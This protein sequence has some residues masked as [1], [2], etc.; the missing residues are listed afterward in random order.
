MASYIPY[1]IA[2]L[3]VN[4]LI[5]L[6]LYL[7]TV[8]PMRT[9]ANGMDLLR[10]QDFSSRLAKVGEPQADRVVELFNRLMTQLKH[11]R[12]AL[13]EQNYLL[14]LIVNASPMGIIQFDDHGAITMKNP[15]ADKLP[16]DSLLPVAAAMKSGDNR[17]VRLSDAMVFRV[18]RLSYMDQ[19][20][21][22][23]FVLIEELTR[24]VMKAEKAAYDK[25]IRLMAHEVNNSAAGINSI[26]D[27]VSASIED[28]DLKEALHVCIER[29]ESMSQFI[30][31]F[32]NVVKI[33]KADLRPVE[34]PEF[35]D[36][37][38]VMLENMCQ[39]AG[40]K[41]AKATSTEF[42]SKAGVTD[43]KILADRV[44]MQQV[45]INIV[46]NAIE[47]QC[48][49]VTISVGGNRLVIANDGQAI[50][51]EVQAKLFTPFYSSKPQGQG[52]GLIFIRE[53]LAQH[54]ATFSLRTD[55]DSIT[56]FS[57]NFPA[58]QGMG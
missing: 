42:A 4:L 55:P 31:A 58:K 3:V 53:V 52:L 8:K 37:M 7:R 21:A 41:L 19:G 49:Q 50:A 14:N 10:A 43:A 44:L 45:V 12:L 15:A 54:S 18:W 25:V 34:L 47:S 16:L 28:G 57:I 32:A 36:Q 22:H 38:W 17:T 20:Y 56:R 24:E 6:L 33:P 1:I 29:F 23:P 5:W 35:V 39:Q 13:R 11:E 40:V 9:I 46:K 26:L 2:A 51:P 27:T 48:R 30:T